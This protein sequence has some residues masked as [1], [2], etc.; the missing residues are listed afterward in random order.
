MIQRREGFRFVLEAREA[1]GVRRERV[2]QNLDGDLAAEGR[3]RRSVH[4]AHPPDT[5]LGGDFIRA[6]ARAWS[7]GQTRAIL[8]ARQA[9]QQVA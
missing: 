3:V 9:E 5:N 4:F 1:F 6:E 2:R 8:R 7:E